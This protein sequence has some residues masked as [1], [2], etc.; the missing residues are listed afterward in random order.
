[1]RKR[2]FS[3]ILLLV[4]IKYSLAQDS[5]TVTLIKKEMINIDSIVTQIE[6]NQPYKE[7]HLTGVSD[8]GRSYEGV[9]YKSTLT[10]EVR[11]IKFFFKPESI[12]LTIYCFDHTILKLKEGSK[13]YYFIYQSYYTTAYQKETSASELN[14]FQDYKGLLTNLFLILDQ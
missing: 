10:K 13:E 14:R 4:L 8:A 7:I 11:K 2:N 1:M 9:A 5:T 12:R 3:L 6:V